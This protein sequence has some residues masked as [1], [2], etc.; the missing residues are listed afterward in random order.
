[1]NDIET[2]EQQ[3]EQP[4]TG[5]LTLVYVLAAG[6][7][8]ANAYSIWQI[9]DM[10]AEMATIQEATNVELA[11]LRENTA[12]TAGAS[13]RSVEKLQ[14]E[15]AA[16]RTEAANAAGGA[17]AAAQRHADTLAK[18]LAE[19][20]RAQQE[21]VA[22]QFNEV[23]ENVTATEAKL[24]SSITEVSGN[25]T[26]VR[27]EVTA[28]KAELDKTIN[29]LKRMNGD[30]GVMSGLIATNGDELKA[31]KDLGERNYFEFDLVKT[32]EAQKLGD[33]RIQLRKTD[34]KRNKFTVDVY[35]DDKRI[36]KKDK[37]MNEPVQ[38][39]AGG[40]RQPYELV[41]YQVKKNQ[42]VGYLATPKVNATRQGGTPL[43]AKSAN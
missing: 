30:M 37:T 42:I 31:L 41:V 32:K 14:E 18:K 26:E 33:I 28:T 19:Q 8:L 9:H 3:P 6:L 11:T 1:M 43:V 25:V 12:Q 39:Y 7:A 21:Q 15:L 27:N 36:E 34:L 16:A 38:F 2:P 22:S 4:K 35:A 24:G 13:Q 40:L 5:S 29:D 17:K 23:R 10:R 20:Q